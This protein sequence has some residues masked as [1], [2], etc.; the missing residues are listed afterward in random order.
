MNTTNV[1]QENIKEGGALATPLRR[2]FLRAPLFLPLLAVVGI[3]VGAWG[4]TLAVFAVLAAAVLKLWRIG[5]AVL[6][7]A[8]LAYLQQERQQQAASALQEY[9]RT[10]EVVELQGTIVR[11]LNK[12]CVL[13]TGWGGVRVVV[14][15]DDVSWKQG[16]YVRL[17]AER[18]RTRIPPVPGMFDSARWMQQQGLAADLRL[19]RG[20]Y[21]GHPFS[22]AAICGAAASVR[23]SLAQRVMPPGTEADARRQV[24]CAL[25]LG[26]KSRAEDET[27]LDFRKGGCLHAFAVSGLHVGLL[28]GILWC[29]LKLCR[30]SMPVSRVVVLVV[31]ALYVVMTGFSVPAIRAYMM[32][33][34]VLVGGML[35]RRVSLL[36]TWSLV[37]LLIL[38]PQPYQIYNAGFQLSFVVYAAICVGARLALREKPWFGPDDYIPYRI[39]TL[40]ERRLSAFELALRGAVLISLWAWLVSLPI[41]IAQFHTLNTHSFL[42]NI[43][44]S[45]LLPLVM[46]S[47]L[48]AMLLGAVPLLGAAVTQLALY[49]AQALIS[50]VAFCGALPA[51]Y[52]PAQIPQSVERMAILSVGYGASVCQMG[53]GGLLIANGNEQTARFNIEPALFHS[54]YTPVALLMPRPSARRAELA[55]VLAGTWPKLQVLDA[56]ELTGKTTLSTPAGVFTIYAPPL[57]LPRTPLD[58]AAPIVA[59]QR[60]KDRVLYV[61]DA[62]LL[63]FE[64]IPAAERR[65]DILILGRNKRMPLAETATIRAIGASRIVL[66]PSVGDFSPD[67]ESLSPAEVRRVPLEPAMYYCEEATSSAY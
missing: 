4:F 48:A 51:A 49:C 47:G 1:E 23:D 26:D 27:M 40:G 42:T 16:D 64:S 60:N 38:L 31:C 53:N 11:E 54:G 20:E 24:L 9:L 67:E 6:L 52:L 36:N 57:D 7:C 65:A 33:A 29:M 2:I 13:D 10:H 19:V 15:G 41:T 56:A 39:R 45:P 30:V 34:V 32:M 12:G 22:W 44:I 14:R 17:V 37:A 5:V 55:A 25:V 21:K 3:L 66:L 63:T 62:S 46:S 8:A 59:W 35:Q 43:L 61:G 28:A 58:N 50:V 18:G